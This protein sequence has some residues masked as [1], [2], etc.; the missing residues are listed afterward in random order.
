M[1]KKNKQTKTSDTQQLFGSRLVDR[2]THVHTEKEKENV[3]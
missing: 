2:Q 1:T 3:F